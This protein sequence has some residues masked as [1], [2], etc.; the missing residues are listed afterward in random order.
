[1]TIAE[2]VAIISEVGV[3]CRDTNSPCLWFTVKISESSGSLQMLS[4][5]EAY[6]LLKGITNV[7]DLDGR[8]C[9]VEVDGNRIRFLRLW[10]QP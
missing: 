2:R 3:G 6:E 5:N 10:S 1:M 7:R 4:W 8:P 9:W